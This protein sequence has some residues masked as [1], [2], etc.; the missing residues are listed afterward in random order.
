MASEKEKAEPP[1]DCRA[2]GDN[3]LIRRLGDRPKPLDGRL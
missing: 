1:L 3:E 2:I